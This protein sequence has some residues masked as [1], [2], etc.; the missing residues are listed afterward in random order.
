MN[1][2]DPD[3]LSPLLGEWQLQP[4]RNPNFRPAVVGRIARLRTQSWATYLQT[5]LA[6]WAVAAV[7]LVAVA[8][9]GGVWAGKA[10]TEK[11]RE[12]MVVSY[13]ADLD[14]RVQAKLRP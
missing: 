5:H 3:N 13:L 12:A 2:P 4:R 1:S 10:R 14:P 8:G 9:V 7:L 11:A 6:G